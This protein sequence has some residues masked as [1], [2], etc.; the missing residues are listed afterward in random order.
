LEPF[1]VNGYW[2]VV[3]GFACVDLHGLRALTK[4]CVTS[5]GVGLGF[6]E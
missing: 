1:R 2:F 4:G 3:I 5:V 6:Y